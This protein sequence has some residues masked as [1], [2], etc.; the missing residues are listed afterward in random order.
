MKS[1]V[2]IV[3]VLFDYVFCFSCVT[4]AKV[5][6]ALVFAKQK[7]SLRS[8]LLRKSGPLLGSA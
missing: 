2:L 8:P 1:H 6:F 4:L 3:V 5:E 7:L